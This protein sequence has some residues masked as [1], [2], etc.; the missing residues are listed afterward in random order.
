MWPDLMPRRDAATEST[1]A[2]DTCEM[3]VIFKSPG[4]HTAS[5][6]KTGFFSLHYPKRKRP[7]AISAVLQAPTTAARQ[8]RDANTLEWSPMCL[9]TRGRDGRC[10]GIARKMWVHVQIVTIVRCGKLWGVL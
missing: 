2:S 3:A 7:E 9:N 6:G 10:R 8:H 4:I 1:A 5:A